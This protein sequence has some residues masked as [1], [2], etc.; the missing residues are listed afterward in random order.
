MVEDVKYARKLIPPYASLKAIITGPY[1]L[2][3]NCEFVHTAYSDYREL[4][5]DFARILNEELREVILAVPDI[6]YVQVD[7]PVFSVDFPDFARELVDLLRDGIDK[8]FALHVCGDV[9]PIFDRLVELGFDILDHEFTERPELLDV[10]ADSGFSG[11]IGYGC[12]DNKSNRVE[13]VAEIEERIGYAI[14]KLGKE[15]LI[16]KPDCGFRYLK[17]ESAFKKMENM[18]KAR[19]NLL[20]VPTIAAKRTYLKRK[21]FDPAGYFYITV[22]EDKGEIVVR[23]YN[24]HHILDRVITGRSALD[25]ANSIINQG[26][27]SE[28][29]NGLRHIAYITEEL[30]KAER[31]LKEGKRY[32]QDEGIE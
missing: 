13:S 15:R 25:I 12:V 28:T 8:E 20:D 30:I 4:A 22:D 26:L 16:I 10:V 24:Y 21:D 7:E 1:T 29:R 9:A 17:R 2:A 19:N 32:I 3:M 31:S 23:H 18:V 27:V 6:V 5:F 14:E 11:K